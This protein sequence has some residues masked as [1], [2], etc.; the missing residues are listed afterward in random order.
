MLLADITDQ[1]GA[2]IAPLTEQLVVVHAELA[3]WHLSATIGRGRLHN[4]ETGGL[5]VVIIPAWRQR[6]T[7]TTGDWAEIQGHITWDPRWGLQLVAA[8]SI[9]RLEASPAAARR[10]QW[11]AQLAVNGSAQH[12]LDI[13][14]GSTRLALIGPGGGD[15]A[16]T[17]VRSVLSQL[18]RSV[19]IQ[20][21]RIPM[22][23][24]KAPIELAQALASLHDQTDVVMIV[25]GG[26][27]SSDLDAWDDPATVERISNYPIPII[28]GIGH[29]TNTSASD[30]VAHYHAVTPTAAATWLV[31][32]LQPALA[33]PGPQV[34]PP[35]DAS[36]PT[37][38]EPPRT[39]LVSAET[40]KSAGFSRSDL[41]LAAVAAVAL[42][43][44]LLLLAF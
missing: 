35:A 28:C 21:I 31:D 41:L 32:L 1:I 16:L 26:G 12:E 30:L 43:V 22:S 25:R 2:A 17:D 38:S 11:H 13:D 19:Q 14:T 34:E 27:A 3:D 4:R 44:V 39:P 7:L 40:W 9:K 23:G 42:V 10:Q 20:V 29:A 5:L 6:H 37:Q 8:Q 18:T 36:S 33:R 15:A 24:P